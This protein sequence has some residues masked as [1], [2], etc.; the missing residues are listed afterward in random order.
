MNPEPTDYPRLPGFEA[1][2]LEDSFVLDI[3]A[4]PGHLRIALDLV[5]TAQHPHYRPPP[6]DEQHCYRKATIDFTNVQALT[7][8]DQGAPPATDVTGTPDY[9]GIDAFTTTADTTH[10][11]GDW[12]TIDVRSALPA[13]SYLD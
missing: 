7:W 11:R 13:I 2:Y 6:P 5:I 3:Q 1:V 10:L 8:T 9:G 4:T 12:G